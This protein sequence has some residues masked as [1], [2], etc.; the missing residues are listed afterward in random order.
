VAGLK[1]KDLVGI[2][3]RVALALQ[4]DG[5]WLRNDIVWAKTN[6]MPE[7]VR[8]RCTVAHEYVFLLA[9]AKRYFY[10]ADAVREPLKPESLVR[11]SGK[12]LPSS[13]KRSQ[14]GVYP[15]PNT[16]NTIHT[17]KSGD[18]LNHNGRNKRTVWTL[19]TQPFPEA[20]FAVYPEALVGPMILAGT[21]AK[22]QCPEC[23]APWERVVETSG[24]TIGRSWHNHEGDLQRGQRA[25]NEAKGGHEY[26]REM[27]GW[28][29]TC[30][31]DAGDTVPCTVLDPFAGAGT[32]GVVAR[33]LGRRF[34]GIELNPEY[35]EMARR[36]YDKTYEVKVKSNGQAVVFEQ[37]RLIG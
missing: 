15:Q 17:I 19:P 36:R 33:K 4:A 22:G 21:S 10:D 29:P 5:W 25:N 3:W 20:H 27:L 24:G 11:W 12:I 6:P 35:A 18:I 14:G 37:K 13:Q 26:K 2:P 23:G 31:C 30:S 28:Q 7:S 32:T 9:R 1:P 8:D 16:V 34:V